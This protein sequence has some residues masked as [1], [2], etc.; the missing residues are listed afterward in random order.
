MTERVLRYELV[1]NLKDL[2]ARYDMAKVL[3]VPQR[4]L[5]L[6]GKEFG[7]KKGEMFAHHA[8][9]GENRSWVEFDKQVVLTRGVWRVIGVVDVQSCVWREKETNNRIVGA[10]TKVLVAEKDN[11]MD[12]VAWLYQANK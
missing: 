6:H 4:V 7:V 2:E 12:L 11:R 1:T 8:I 9:L 10:G 3:S 5:N